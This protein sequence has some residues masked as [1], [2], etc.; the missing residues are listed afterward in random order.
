MQVGFVNAWLPDKGNGWITRDNEKGSIFVH[1]SGLLDDL[2]HLD[3]EDNMRFEVS[4]SSG[5]D[6]KPCS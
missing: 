6:G 1:L 3:K 5:K 4:W 2:E